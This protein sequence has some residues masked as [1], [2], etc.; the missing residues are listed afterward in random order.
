MTDLQ[1]A[2]RNLA[3]SDTAVKTAA[4]ELNTIFKAA[5]ADYNARRYLQDARYNQRGALLY[6]VRV[7]MDGV[8]SDRHRSRS[9]H[10]FYGMLCAQAGVAIASM[11]LAARL[12]SLLW[13]L[14]GFAGLIALVFSSYVYLRM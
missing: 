11:A 7:H 1:T 10:F 14:A 8:A 12:K 4:E 13:G 2:A 5:R 6:E 9:Q 3:R